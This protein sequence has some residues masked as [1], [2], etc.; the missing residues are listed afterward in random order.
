M[1]EQS[2]STQ[3][4]TTANNQNTGVISDSRETTGINTKHLAEADSR[5]SHYGVGTNTDVT[6]PTPTGSEEWFWAEGVKGEGIKPEFMSD[7][8][9]TVADQAKAYKESMRALAKNV[10][11]TYEID[12]NPELVKA[13]L[14]IDIESPHMQQFEQF[15]RENGMTNDQVNGALNIYLE[16]LKDLHGVKQENIVAHQKAE[17]EKLGQDAPKIIAQINNW[18]ENNLDEAE[19]KSLREFADSAERITFLKKLINKTTTSTANLPTHGVNMSTVNR[20]YIKQ[21]QSDPRYARDLAFTKKADQIAKAWF[22]AGQK[23]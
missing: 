4:Q 7:K 10:P 18:A 3:S 19:T 21:L 11:E 1:L 13:G 23:Y 22:D 14:D 8:Y 9:K 5:R 17:M 6:L 16:S 20:D 12:I 15:A 2:T